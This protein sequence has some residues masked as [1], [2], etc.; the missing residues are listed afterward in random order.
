MSKIQSYVANMDYGVFTKDSK[1]QDAVV[2]NLEI[3]GEAVKKLSFEIKEANPDVPWKIIAATR[4]R[5]IHEYFGINIDIIWEIAT[6]D[7]T[8]LRAKIDKIKSGLSTDLLI[9]E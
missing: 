2:R 8:E 3:I 1:T 6:S 4:D 5:L 7:L 9:K